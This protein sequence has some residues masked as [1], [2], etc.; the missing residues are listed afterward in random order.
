VGGGGEN[1]GAWSDAPYAWI[2]QQADSQRI[3]ILAA[4]P[5]D[6]WLPT[7]LRS[8]GA[9]SAFNLTIGSAAVANDSATWRAIVACRGVFIKGGDQWDYVR[10]WRNTLTEDAIRAVFLAGGV[11]AGTSAGAAVLGEFVYDARVSSAVSRTVLRNPRHSSLTFTTG[12]LDLVPGCIFDTHFYERGRFGRLLTMM[13]RLGAD[14][15]RSVTGIGL[16]AETALC[17]PPDGEAE[18]MG[19]GAVV[20]YV[21]TTLTRSRVQ[22][23]LPLVYTDIRTDILTSGFRYNLHSRQVTSLPPSATAPLPATTHPVVNRLLLFGDSI[24]SAAGVSAVLAAAGGPAGEFAVITNPASPAGGQRWRDSLLGRGASSATLL[25]LDAAGSQNPA[26]A[27]AIMEAEGLVFAGSLSE[28]VPAY[29]DPATAVG[30]A[31]HTRLAGGTAVA[32]A[33]QDAKLAG[34]AVVF[35]TELEELAS[36][37]GKLTLG[38]GVRALRNLVVMPLIFQ[39]GVFDENRTAGLPWGMARTGAR[40]G[41]YV[42]DGGWVETEPSG[43]MA[44]YGPTP[45]VVLDAN[46]AAAVDYSTYRHSGSIGPRQSAALTAARIHVISGD[47]RFDPIGGAIITAAGEGDVRLPDRMLLL[48]AYPNPF[49]GSATISFVLGGTEPAVDMELRVF[50]LLGR[51]VALLAAGEHR[52]GAHSVRFDASGLASGVY[53][54]RLRAGAAATTSLLLLLR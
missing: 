52:P 15:G 12:F 22:S 2:V 24:P 5:A 20:F 11:V 7:Y 32:F 42:D 10:D 41:I 3:A 26:F 46:G 33:G 37:R 38:S 6:A 17:I 14:S 1:Y 34:S 4:D 50:D 47:V 16:E 43:V 51:E 8:L 9:D 36:I 18:V 48:Q 19:A 39:S 29:L 13:A 23:D 30:Q 35:R 45:A 40:T 49:N 53:L 31:L 21:P 28:A 54:L 44:A 27:S 25:L